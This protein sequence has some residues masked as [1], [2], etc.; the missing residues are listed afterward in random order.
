MSNNK[1]HKIEVITKMKRL[2]FYV[3]DYDYKRLTEYAKRRGL[4]ID[5]FCRMTAFQWLERYPSKKIKKQ[6]T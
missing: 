2:Q 5:N 4:T 3:N 6:K 1:D